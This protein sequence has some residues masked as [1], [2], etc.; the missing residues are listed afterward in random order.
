MK[1]WRGLLW[2]CLA[3]LVARHGHAQT[4]TTLLET[5]TETFNHLPLLGRNTYSY[6]Y[7]SFSQYQP[8]LE[9]PSVGWLS[10]MQAD[11]PL[12]FDFHPILT[13]NLYNDFPKKFANKKMLGMSYY[14]AFRPQF[15]MYQKES[16]PVSMPSYRIFVGLRHLYRINEKHY[17][18][19]GFESGHYSNG[20]RGCPIDG[21][22]IDLTDECDSIFRNLAGDADLSALINRIDGD[23]STNLSQLTF[24]YR[25]VP[26]LDK[27]QRPQ[28]VH[29][30]TLGFSV[31]HNLLFGM[32]PVGGY[33][34]PAI[35]IYGRG[36]ILMGYNYTYLWQNGYRFQV[37]EDME[38]IAG[39]HR[40]VNP[41]RS[42]TTFTFFLPRNTGIYMSYTY[43]HDN[44]NLRFVD[45]G[46]QFGIGVVWDMFAP[47]EVGEEE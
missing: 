34:E 26:K 39:A 12:I 33:V 1:I 22:G 38:L 21:G 20:Q 15:R 31:Y 25:Y 27:Y 35:K 40:S 29:A 4:D 23:Y 6:N 47:T 19:Y 43:G 30:A 5:I 18:G 28:Q 14:L 17:V 3:L 41:F 11:E 16:K 13:L 10:K 24:T 42:T 7:K 45:S 44:Y 32:I 46:H 2:M 8:A 37:S 36:R 9:N